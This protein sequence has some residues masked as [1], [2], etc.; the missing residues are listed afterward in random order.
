MTDVVYYVVMSGII[1]FL[2]CVLTQVLA[3][4]DPF[5][6]VLCW[7]LEPNQSLMPAKISARTDHFRNGVNNDTNVTVTR[8]DKL[9]KETSTM[10][11]S[12]FR[13]TYLNFPNIY[14]VTAEWAR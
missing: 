3:E 11:Y 7:Q 2:L 6:Q 12:Q 10:T 13:S 9:G 5:G 8:N 4:A 1:I 14:T